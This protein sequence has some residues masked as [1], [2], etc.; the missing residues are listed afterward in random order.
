LRLKVIHMEK[1]WFILAY[2][3]LWQR[4]FTQKNTVFVPIYKSQVDYTED[5]TFYLGFTL[6]QPD[7]IVVD[8]EVNMAVNLVLTK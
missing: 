5:Q 2:R 7:F 6:V 4:L 1:L 8:V 3:E